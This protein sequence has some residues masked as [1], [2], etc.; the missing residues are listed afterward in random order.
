MQATLRELHGAV[1][2]EELVGMRES[3]SLSV[4]DVDTK[5]TAAVDVSEEAAR[6]DMEATPQ[7]PNGLIELEEAGAMRKS[8][9][10]ELYFPS[11]GVIDI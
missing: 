8:L 9:S 3:F 11:M 4:G 2:T 7:E 10:S 6:L 1:V 5:T